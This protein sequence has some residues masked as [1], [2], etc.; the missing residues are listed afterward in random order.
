MSVILYF[1]SIRRSKQIIKK[2]LE[3]GRFAF[4][5]GHLFLPLAMKFAHE[6]Q[7]VL[8]KENFP[9]AWRELAIS[10]SQLKKCIKKLQG[11]LLDLGLDARTLSELL[12]SAEPGLG[13]SGLRPDKRPLFQ[14][15]FGGMYA[16]IYSICLLNVIFC[17]T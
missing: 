11:E 8:R 2:P 10:Y 7:D 15:A 9:A 13:S 12:V 17:V 14:Y 1:L 6:F 16:N 5:R 4:A 3:T